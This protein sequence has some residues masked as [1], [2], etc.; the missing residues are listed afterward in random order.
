MCKMLF[1][2]CTKL[3]AF[4]SFISCVAALLELIIEPQSEEQR[5]AFCQH[6][7]AI[8]RDVII[9]NSV[10]TAGRYAYT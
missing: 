6:S 3:N 5:S 10:W 7:E 2:W 4:S 9:P 1:S 8:V